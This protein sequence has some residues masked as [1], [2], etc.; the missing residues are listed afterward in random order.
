MLSLV[1]PRVFAESL[2]SSDSALKVPP[3]NWLW[4]VP[5]RVAAVTV[6]PSGMAEMLYDL[7]AV[8]VLEIKFEPQDQVTSGPMYF[9]PSPLCV[10]IHAHSAS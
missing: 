1:V 8:P 5:E 9:S 10:A 4:I 6:L 3:H 7:L 2:T